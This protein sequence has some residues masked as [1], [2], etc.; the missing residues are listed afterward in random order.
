[1]RWLR[2]RSRIF[3]G[4]VCS[5]NPISRSGSPGGEGDGCLRGRRR[6]SLKARIDEWFLGRDGLGAL[7]AE[8]RGDTRSGG[9]GEEEKGVIFLGK[10]QEGRNFVAFR[11]PGGGYRY[12]SGIWRRSFV[13]ERE[14]EGVRGFVL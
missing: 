5:L 10:R 4:G 12:K 1:M 13:C 7:W 8:A 9:W 2:I 3:G 11:P 6:V 14:G